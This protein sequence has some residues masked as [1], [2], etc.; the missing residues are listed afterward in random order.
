[1]NVESFRL[2]D[3]LEWTVGEV[4]DFLASILPGQPCL[5]YFRHTSGY[6]LC[7]LEKEDLRKQ[8]KNDEATNVIWMELASRRKGA[9]P[10]RAAGGNK[11]L[12]QRGG[13]DPR[14]TLTLYVKAPRQGAALELEML[15]LDT[16][17]FLKA[18]IEVHEGAPPDSQRLVFR[19]STMQDDR[20]LTSYG[21][22]HGDSV[23]LIPTLR[24]KVAQRRA[25]FAPRGLLSLPGSKAW[26]PSSRSPFLPVLFS[27]VSRNF[28]ISMEFSAVADCEAFAEAARYAPPWLEILP[29]GP[30]RPP[31]DVKC[32]LDPDHG[33]VCLEATSGRGG[34]V[35][36]STY[37]AV[38][39]FGGRGGQ[40]QV[41]LVT[42]SAVS[43]C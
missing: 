20:S 5:D 29:G 34:F 8:T 11:A 31:A 10:V 42:G 7:S 30:G 37:Q 4:G 19:G 16:I 27:D 21:L 36:N 15:P 13:L 22:Q 43:V 2:K 17:A 14:S 28:P 33:A 40:V 24:D 25:V 1:M 9:S 18:Q 32:R 23:L 3:P 6:V 41:C 38:A 12:V 26:S 39:H 35:P